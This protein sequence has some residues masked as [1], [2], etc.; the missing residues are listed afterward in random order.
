MV[1]GM[2]GFQSEA[3]A[4]FMASLEGRFHAPA[5]GQLKDFYP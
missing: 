3:D 5:A 1:L 4:H 2:P